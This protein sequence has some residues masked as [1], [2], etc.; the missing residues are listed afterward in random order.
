MVLSSTCFPYRFI[1]KPDNGNY[2]VIAYFYS[3]LFFII[4]NQAKQKKNSNQKL[5]HLHLQFI[6]L[7]TMLTINYTDYFTYKNLLYL[8]E[9]ETNKK[10]DLQFL[11]YLNH[12]HS[13][14]E[15]ILLTIRN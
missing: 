6:Q 13:Y 8:T 2:S 1:A 5:K 7:L 9:L 14:E 4:I 15:I 10:A 11:R 12:L 3:F